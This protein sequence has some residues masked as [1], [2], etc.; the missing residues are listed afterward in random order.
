[1]V[2]QAEAQRDVAEAQYRQAV[3]EALQDAETSLSQFGNR[4]QQLLQLIAAERAATRSAQLNALRV[5]AGTSTVI[6][7]LDIERQRYSATLSVA[8]ATAQ[9][10]RSYVAVQKALGLG[11]AEPVAKPTA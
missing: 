6:D 3:L 8:Q 1:M 7:Q 10:T 2:R 9:L 11:W 5:K 4:R